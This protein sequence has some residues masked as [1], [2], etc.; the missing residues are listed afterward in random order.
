MGFQHGLSGLSVA[1]QSLDVI[2]NNIA[3][4]NTVG[5][6]QGQA[7][8]SDVY[9]NALSGAVAD[10]RGMGAKIANIAQEFSQGTITATNN[11]LDIA[12][13]GNGFF[14]M[15]NDGAV[16]YSRNGQFHIDADGFIVNN[17]NLNLTGYS[18]DANGEIL[19]ADPTNLRISTAALTPDATTEFNT[20][21][22]LDSRTTVP[23][24]LPA[25]DAN[26]PATY[27]GTTSG[28]I[29]DSL[30]NSHI[31]SIYFQKN[32]A[33]TWDMFATVDGETTPAGV[34]VG[35]TLGGG[36][37]QAVTFDS[38]GNLTAPAAPIAVSVD[39]AAINPALGATSPLDF[40]LDLDG[41]TQFGTAFGVNALSQD[42]FSSGTI[43][44]F[45]IDE[46][47]L[48]SGNYTNGES[49]TLGQLILA[50]FSNP[51]G[52][53]PIGDNQWIESRA[54]GQPLI[55]TPGT[56][57]MGVLQSAAVE[58]ANVDLTAELVDMITTQRVYQANAK[59]IETQDAILQTLVNL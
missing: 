13:N 27:N 8:F 4:A 54:S 35:V 32:A 56:G 14:R 2:G 6:K 23:A 19:T 29:Y 49:M 26:D 33:N 15:S 18:T 43:A 39:L 1:S 30:G 20:S 52:L 59:T 57:V 12:I 5:F 36:A 44:G 47:G 10:Q 7:Q 45:S 28:T 31:F 22:N 3:N 40:T 34:P 16:S 53:T 46:E 42:G 17:N 25:F 58:E 21:L 48:I 24:A 50:N 9:A 55:G 38:N 41:T 11:P 51:H 37:S